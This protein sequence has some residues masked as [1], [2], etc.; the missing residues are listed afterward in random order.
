MKCIWLIASVGRPRGFGSDPPT[1]SGR[2]GLGGRHRFHT[3]I[4]YQSFIPGFLQLLLFLYSL[5]LNQNNGFFFSPK[6]V[7]PRLQNTKMRFFFFYILEG[8]VWLK[9]VWPKVCLI[10]FLVLSFKSFF[11]ILFALLVITFLL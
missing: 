6:P 10:A 4:P 1:G 9:G 3:R 2:A 5:C 8:H 11:F 7:S